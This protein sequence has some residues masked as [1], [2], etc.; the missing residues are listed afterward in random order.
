MLQEVPSGFSLDMLAQPAALTTLATSAL[1]DLP[2]DLSRFVR[3]IFTGMGSS[4]YATI[5]LELRLAERGLPVWRLQTS[6]LLDTPGMLSDNTLLW[7]TSQSGRSGEVVALLERLPRDRRITIVATTNDPDS[8][9]AQAAAHVLR[10][11]S[12]TEATVSCKS[13]LNTLAVLHRAGTRL[14]GE[15]DARA[16]DD[17]HR[18]AEA[19]PERLARPSPVIRRLAET[20]QDHPGRRFALVGAGADATTALTGALILKEAAKVPAEGYVGGAFRHGPMELAGPDLA[21]LLFGSGSYDADASLAQLS[22]DLAGTGSSVVSVGPTPLPDAEHV[23]VTASS[24]L[25]RLAEA[26]V[27][28]QQ[29]SIELAHGSGIVPGAFR[30]GQ[31]ITAQL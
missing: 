29:L 14:C 1:P 11:H 18:L 8:P 25:G 30:F 6:R 24:T 20:L 2:A 17:I 5:P 12:G 10:L 26:M 31:K 7:I 13:Y 27:V 21:I 19:L 4:D 3:I 16:L 22:R 23:P 9:I 28:I 15:S